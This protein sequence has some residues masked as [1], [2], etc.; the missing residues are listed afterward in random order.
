[1]DNLL[2]FTVV[3]V[4][5]GIGWWLGRSERL[6][7]SGAPGSDGLAPSYYQGLNY[8]L[9]E[10]PDR[11]VSAFIQDLEVNEDT[12]ETHLAMGNLL[13]RRGEVEKALIVHENILAAGNLARD[14]VLSVQL[15]LARDYLL[16]GLLDRAE[17]LLAGLAKES[18][19]VRQLSLRMTLEIY[20]QER[21][22]RKAI[23]IAEMLAGDAEG[24]H[25]STISHYYCELAE[26]A[27][28]GNRFEDARGELSRAIGHDSENPRCSLV[29]GKIHFLE[30]KYVE[31]VEALRR[32]KDQN[33]AF[34]S[35]SL[36]LLVEAY[37]KSGLGRDDL[38]FYLE[39]CL[40]IQPA[41]S[42]VLV[43]AGMLREELRE[44]EGD[45]AVARFLAD[46]LKKNPSIKGL[47]QLIEYHMDNT[48]GVAKEN[49]AILRS[50]TDAIVSEKPSHRC[51]E[52][53]F[54]S[55]K[56]HWHCPTCKSWGSVLPVFGLEGE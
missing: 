21:E 37:K 4:A 23:S 55:K 39:K 19:S 47:T 24:D 35:E 1:M 18:G 15:E 8:L 51:R 2:L 13:R 22:W 16:A 34:V 33:A 26:E 30:G 17:V 29:L 11:A 3:F 32:I 5:I 9:N 52:C 10:R 7:S 6:R 12:L 31:A 44:E 50:F 38:R 14:I 25:E 41:I 43:L 27:I 28:E 53:G 36:E 40:E 46:H 56:N 49:L 45:E 48:T 42:I 20:E 54:F